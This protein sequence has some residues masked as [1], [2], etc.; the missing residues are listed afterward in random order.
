VPREILASTHVGSQ[1][2]RPRL[3]NQDQ[4]LFFRRIGA[5]LEV[6]SPPGQTAGYRLY[7]GHRDSIAWRDIAATP[8]A[9][10]LVGRHP[11]C[12][13]Y[14]GGDPE[15]SLRHLLLTVTPQGDGP[16]TLR[17]LNLRS[18]LPFFL[19]DDTPRWSITTT[20]AV[21]LRLGRY[22]LAALPSRAGHGLVVPERGFDELP[23]YCKVETTGGRRSEPPPTEAFSRVT[24]APPIAELAHLSSSN[25]TEAFARLI[26]QGNG[27]GVSINLTEVDLEQGVLIGRSSKCHDRNMQAVLSKNISRTHLLLLREGGRSFAYD[28]CS[29]NGTYVEAQE[30]SSVELGAQASLELGQ[31]EVIRLRWQALPRLSG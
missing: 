26:V 3:T 31:G 18:P 21:V 4:R 13:I 30:R 9:H 29:T 5:L 8:G 24:M 20:G 15:L 7:W 2:E 25:D 14:L 23:A 12:G 1:P 27:A 11:H 19:D 16:P 10:A 17:L 28:L 22:T 6:D